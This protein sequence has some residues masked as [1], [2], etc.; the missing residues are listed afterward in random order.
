MSKKTSGALQCLDAVPHISKE[1]ILQAMRD[2]VALT[3]EEMAH[4][5]S[6]VGCMDFF[7]KLVIESNAPGPQTDLTITC[8]GTH[9]R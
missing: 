4:L 3:D 7:S 2:E 1:K 5:L 9:T 6:C 8:R